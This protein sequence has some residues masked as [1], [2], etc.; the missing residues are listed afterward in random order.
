[1]LSPLLTCAETHSLSHTHSQTDILKGIPTHKVLIS[2]HSG[3]IRIMCC[4]TQ[5]KNRPEDRNV[6]K[7]GKRFLT[8]AN[9]PVNHWCVGYITAGENGK[10]KKTHRASLASVCIKTWLWRRAQL[11]IHLDMKGEE[12]LKI[13]Q[14]SSIG[15]TRLNEQLL[16]SLLVIEDRG[17]CLGN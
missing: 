1:M 14:T 9:P 6:R 12:K 8:W 16:S 11:L 10:N 13:W 4:F 15:L 17:C 3:F 7:C 2:R 5:L